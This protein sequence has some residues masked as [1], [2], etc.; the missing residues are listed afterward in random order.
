MSHGIWK[1]PISLQVIFQ[2]LR[3]G[4]GGRISDDSDY[5]QAFDKFYFLDSGFTLS[6]FTLSNLSYI[7]TSVHWELGLPKSLTL[8]NQSHACVELSARPSFR[9]YLGEKGIL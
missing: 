6:N 4:Y 3:A 1:S 8:I 2:R 9:T 7:F 5:T